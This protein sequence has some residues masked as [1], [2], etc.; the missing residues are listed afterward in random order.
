MEIKPLKRGTLLRH[1]S[2]NNN[3][4]LT[5]SSHC[6]C[7]PNCDKFY[8]TDGMWYYY[9]NYEIYKTKT[10]KGNKLL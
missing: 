7:R 3:N 9:E 1:Y 5:Y 6:T 8:A 10:K 4:I 2:N